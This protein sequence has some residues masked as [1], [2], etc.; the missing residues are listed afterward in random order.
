[1]K[2]FSNVNNRSLRYSTG[3][4]LQLFLIKMSLEGNQPLCMQRRMPS[5]VTIFKTYLYSA[6]K[7]RAL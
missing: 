1:M 6:V 3:I 5:A 4:L 2:Q 7:Q